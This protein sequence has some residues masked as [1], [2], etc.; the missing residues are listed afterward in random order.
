V[1]SWMARRAR[2]A[3]LAELTGSGQARLNPAG[4][5][6]P[7]REEAKRIDHSAIHPPHGAV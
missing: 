6:R 1:S 7:N 3:L 5:A 4:R 2:K